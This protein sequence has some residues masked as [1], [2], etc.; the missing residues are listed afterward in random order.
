MPIDI[1]RHII[2]VIC[3]SSNGLKDLNMFLLDV[4]GLQKPLNEDRSLKN[5]MKSDK[6]IKRFRQVCDFPQN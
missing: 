2:C 5:E 4:L 1:H 6:S 3:K